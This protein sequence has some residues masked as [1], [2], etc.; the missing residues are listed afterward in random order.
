VLS[1]QEALLKEVISLVEEFQTGSG[2]VSSKDTDF[3]GADDLPSVLET[4]ELKDL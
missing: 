1:S 2:P 4:G 3:L